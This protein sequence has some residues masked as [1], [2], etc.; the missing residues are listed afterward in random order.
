ML[1]IYIY[2]YITL[3]SSVNGFGLLNGFLSVFS[4]WFHQSQLVFPHLRSDVA[5]DPKFR[6]QVQAPEFSS[7][8]KS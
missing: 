5:S 6:S 1:H 2:I 8:L 4:H 3:Y 7:N